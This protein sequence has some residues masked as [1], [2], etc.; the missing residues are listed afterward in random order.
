MADYY[1]LG[2][3]GEEPK[4]PVDLDTLR[5]W[6]QEGLIQ[7]QSRLK[8][9]ESGAVV[10]ASRLRGMDF[11]GTQLKIS[12]NYANPFIASPYPRNLFP[13]RNEEAAAEVRLAWI[14]VAL[15]FAFVC[16]YGFGTFFFGLAIYRANLAKA[17][18]DDPGLVPRVIAILGLSMFISGL[19]LALVASNR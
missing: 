4:G 15:G 6:S 16:C 11:E 8:N 7:P 17:W 13:V 5:A 18:G 2:D 1:V 3:S 19:L 14:C 10:L 9:A 12:Q